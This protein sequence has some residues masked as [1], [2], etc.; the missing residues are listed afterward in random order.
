MRRAMSLVFSV[1]VVIIYVVAI[2]KVIFE[3]IV[4]LDFDLDLDLEINVVTIFMDHSKNLCNLEEM[5]LLPMMS[6]E[7]LKMFC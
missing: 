6:T 7:V 1:V 2:F 3:L 5:L 4:F